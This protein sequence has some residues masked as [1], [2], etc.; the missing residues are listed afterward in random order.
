MEEYDQPGDFWVGKSIPRLGGVS[1]FD[2]GKYMV[3]KKQ[4][5]HCELMGLLS[6]PRGGDRL[7]I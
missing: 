2:N 1:K 5:A 6:K 4:V 3:A 7:T